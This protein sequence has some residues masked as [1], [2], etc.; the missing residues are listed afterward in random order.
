MSHPI[1]P[2]ELSDS[3]LAQVVGGIS[4]PGAPPSSPPATTLSAQPAVANTVASSTVAGQF[5]YVAN[6]SLPSVAV[7]MPTT[8]GGSAI[9]ASTATAA[10]APSTT[11]AIIVS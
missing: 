11:L 4:G 6:V 1:N 9:S 8:S 3:E 7:P 10:H 5:G 2:D